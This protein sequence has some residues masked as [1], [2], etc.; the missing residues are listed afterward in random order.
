MRIRFVAAIT[1]VGLIALAS[2]SQ[3][4]AQRTG[5]APAPA[6]GIAVVDLRVVVRDSEKIRQAK[7]ELKAEAQAKEESLKKERERGNQ[8]TEKLRSMPKGTPEW[9][10]LERD[11]LKLRADFEL[12]GA[13][14]DRELRET[15]MKVMFALLHDVNE[16]LKRYS[17]ANGV[18]LVL[19]KDAT[20]PDLNDP[21]VVAQEITKRIVYQRGADITPAISEAINRRGPGNPAT[22]RNPSAPVKR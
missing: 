4:L 16:A 9:K 22:S 2:V 19:G 12:H 5:A 20:P 7:E 13:R 11:V 1:V 3:I 18:Q 6:N 10:Q 17:Q 8:L 14:A 21:Q 15:E